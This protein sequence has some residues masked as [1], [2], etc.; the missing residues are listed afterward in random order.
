M[1]YSYG[2]TD[3][4]GQA[5]CCDQCGQP[6]GARK[7]ACVHKVLWSAFR[8]GTGQRHQLHYCPAPAL[9]GP[10]L[11][12]LGGIRKLHEQCAAG[13]AA[14]QIEQDATQVLYESGVPLCTYAIGRDDDVPEGK[15]KVGFETCDGVKSEYLVDLDEYQAVGYGRA[16]ALA[17]YRSA[18]PFGEAVA[19]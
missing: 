13:A 19:A 6:G 7:R 14:S 8:S 4:G 9:C 15:C 12:Q 2:R 16:T 3:S 11:K 18:Q 5:L 10:C 17:E 1:G